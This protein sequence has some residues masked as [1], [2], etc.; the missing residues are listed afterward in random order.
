MFLS[1][2]RAILEHISYLCLS[3]STSPL[4]NHPSL[5]D[6]DMSQLMIFFQMVENSRGILTFI[7]S[8]S[9]VFRLQCLWST[10]GQMSGGRVHFRKFNFG[11]TERNA[12]IITN[13]SRSLYPLS[14]TSDLP[15]IRVKTKQKPLCPRTKYKNT[16]KNTTT[17]NWLLDTWLLPKPKQIKRIKQIILHLIW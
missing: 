17:T 10:Q 1:N 8:L 16:G 13:F 12:D 6:F 3:V 14:L 9:F 15:L 11:E 5:H 2:W 7:P 4:P